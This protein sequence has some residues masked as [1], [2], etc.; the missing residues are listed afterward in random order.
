M[1]TFLRLSSGTLADEEHGLAGQ[2]VAITDALE[3]LTGFSRGP[4]GKVAIKVLRARR[5]RL[6]R[7]HRSDADYLRR[8]ATAGPL[9][10]RGFQKGRL[11]RT[12]SPSTAKFVPDSPVAHRTELAQRFDPPEP[13]GLG[14]FVLCRLGSRCSRLERW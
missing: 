7:R 4:D 1:T 10:C 5:L 9:T 11:G 2:A 8:R 14:P 12:W 13:K 3:A 6:G